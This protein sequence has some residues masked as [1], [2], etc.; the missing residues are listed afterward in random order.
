[1][2]SRRRLV[3]VGGFA[4]LVLLAIGLLALRWQAQPTGLSEEQ[5][6]SL[7]LARSFVAGQG[8]RL[9][10]MSSPLPGPHN[11]VWFAAQVATVGAGVDAQ[12]WLPRLA[13]LCVALT[14]VLVS[15][16]SALV[17]RRQVRLEDALPAVG[18]SLA[19][20]FAEATR[21]GSG[22]AAWVLGLSLVAV[23]VG[24]GLPTGSAVGAGVA[25]GVLCLLRPSAV[26]LLVASA[27]AWWLAAK[28]EGRRAGRET[29]AFLAAGLFISALIFGGRL[30]LLG[31][32]PVDGLFPS[33]SGAAATQDFLER[34]SRW[35]FAGLTALMVATVWRRFHMRG[36]ATLL[37]WVLMTVV[38][39]NWSENPR[40]LFLGC[41][42]LLAMVVGDGLSV[43]REATMDTG[44][45]GP[46]RGV[47][48]VAFVTT[49]VLL[50]LASAASFFLGPVMK[51][52]PTVQA[53]P[54]F[55][56]ELRQRA[57]Q[58]P[59]VAWTD[60]VE[61]AT[62]FPNA[63]VVVVHA[64]SPRV[65]DLL[66]SEGPPDVV[67]ARIDMK[68]MPKLSGLVQQGVGG[69]FWLVGQTTDEDPRCPDGRLSLLST[70]GAELLQRL[71]QDVNEEQLTRALSRWRCALA[72]LETVRLPPADRRRAVGDLVSAK[73]R[74]FE[75]QGRLELS[76]R[77][78]SLA[79][80]LTNEEVQ[81][82]A[83]A[84]RLRGEF[85]AQ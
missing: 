46:L 72:A 84:E 69:A 66:T 11:L 50:V 53:Q 67:D 19:T 13:L 2:S 49:A 23:I 51:V 18:L 70:D 8:L 82:R 21:L 29:I 37:A 20:A 28:V 34:Q 52:A 61:A 5:A 15:V 43:A 41:G 59:L 54:E 68:A 56:K 26:W 14:L 36:G 12:V 6:E 60:G 64:A 57:V 76:L 77:A 45:E 33:T 44:R 42:P 63:R 74:Q 3:E 27:P 24:R 38:L 1:M 85:F 35:F 55:D 16:R 7:V 32:L 75:Q 83:R 73:S 62:L 47:A 10:P 71:E 78:A 58:T 39:A 65:E 40:T 30:L 22:S 48:W 4:L 9:T 80:S 31:E 81:L 25:M 17:W 79:A